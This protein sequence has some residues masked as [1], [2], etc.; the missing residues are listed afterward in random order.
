MSECTIRGC[1]KLK[2]VCEDCGRTVCTADLNNEWISI[3]DQV[4][5]VDQKVLAW[6]GRVYIAHYPGPL[7]DESYQ[8]HW[9]VCYDHDCCC[10]G[11]TGAITHWMPLPESPNE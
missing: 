2:T 10:S 9:L 11:A 3:K 1:R 6:G 7:S 8:E 4:P 5:L